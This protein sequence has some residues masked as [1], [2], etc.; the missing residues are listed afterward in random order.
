MY[1]RSI[2]ARS[3]CAGK[4]PSPSND[5]VQNTAQSKPVRRAA[6]P[7]SLQFAPLP[8]RPAPVP[9]RGGLRPRTMCSG[10]GADGRRHRT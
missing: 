3:Q 2:R 5:I 7:F 4:D 10:D 9:L 6:A 8:H 1:E